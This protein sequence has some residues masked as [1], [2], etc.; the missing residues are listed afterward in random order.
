MGAGM[1]SVLSARLIQLDQSLQSIRQ[2]RIKREPP[3]GG[4]RGRSRRDKLEHETRDL[5]RQS[6][7][8]CTPACRYGSLAVRPGVPCP[9]QHLT[10]GRE[11]TDRN[12]LHLSRVRDQPKS[13]TYSKLETSSGIVRVTMAGVVPTLHA[14]FP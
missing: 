4:R 2:N 5:L 12:R 8:P 11:V 6:R 1:P 10:L 7:C 14:Y 13:I 3:Y 9:A